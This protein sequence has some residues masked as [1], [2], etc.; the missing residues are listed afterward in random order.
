[1][2]IPNYPKDDATEAAG[3]QAGLASQIVPIDMQQ[4]LPVRHQAHV[5]APLPSLPHRMPVR[6]NL[7]LGGPRYR[8][9][10]SSVSADRNFTQGRAQSFRHSA[11]RARSHHRA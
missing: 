9:A 3:R 6:F 10:F 1:M 5:T 7:F 4:V 8:S 11:A 2:C